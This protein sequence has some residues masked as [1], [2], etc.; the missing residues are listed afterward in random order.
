MRTGQ[1]TGYHSRENGSRTD[2]K[3]T[4]TTAS[5]TRSYDCFENLGEHRKHGV[6][7]IICLSAIVR[8]HDPTAFDVMLGQERSAPQYASRPTTEGQEEDTTSS[9]HSSEE[10]HNEAHGHTINHEK[11]QEWD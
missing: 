3:R 6:T 4:W 10:G 9:T 7:F 11:M 5:T 2:T 8:I 1:R